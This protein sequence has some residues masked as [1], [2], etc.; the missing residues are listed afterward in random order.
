MN[1]KIILMSIQSYFARQ[2]FAGAKRFEFRKSSIREQD[3]GKTIYVYSAKEDRAIIGS[4]VVK[5]VHKGGLQEILRITGYDKRADKQEIVDYYK[6][7]AVCYALELEKVKMFAKPLTLNE[8][9]KVEPRLQ[10]PQ[11]WAYIKKGSKLFEM[12]EKLK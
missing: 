1:D 2:I 6:N 11:Y 12:I 8:M 4:F 9:R 5:M 7:S 3:I 10:L